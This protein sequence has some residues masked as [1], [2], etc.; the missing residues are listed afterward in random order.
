MRKL[1]NLVLIFFLSTFIGC[2]SHH[3][4]S[5][6]NQWYN[7][8]I[9]KNPYKDWYHHLLD[10]GINKYT[11]KDD[12][13]FASFLGMD[14]IYLRLCWSYLEPQERKFDWHYIDEVVEKYVPKGY[15]ISFR[16]S[17]SETGSYPGSVGEEVMECN[18]TPNWIQKAGAKGTI[19]D[20]GNGRTKSWVPKWDDP[21]FSRKARPIS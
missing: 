17:C 8:R 2:L 10:N 7:S 12:S 4:I 3:E 5:F 19:V 21:V 13:I 6:T 16:I 9:L 14:H 15:K 11:I 1:Q 18:M 20:R